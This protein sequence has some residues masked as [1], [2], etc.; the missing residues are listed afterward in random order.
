[1]MRREIRRDCAGETAIVG[2]RMVLDTD[3]RS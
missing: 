2:N 1:M 3:G